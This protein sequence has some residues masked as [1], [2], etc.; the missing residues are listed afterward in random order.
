MSRG[1]RKSKR[2]KHHHPKGPSRPPAASTRPSPPQH[3]RAGHRIR[4]LAAIAVTVA[5]L[6]VVGFVWIVRPPPLHPE[7]WDVPEV[8][9]RDVRGPVARAVASARGALFERPTSAEA[10]GE[11][12]MVFDAHEMFDQAATCYGRAHELS[13][14]DFRWVYFLG[15]VN[16]L[17]GADLNA[18]VS[19]FEAAIRL[20]PDYVAV[21]YRFGEALV[22]HGRMAEARDTFGHLVKLSPDLAT[23]YRGLGQVLLTM[24]EPEP[25]V[26]HLLRAA[27]LKPDEAKIFVALARGYT[28]LGDHARAAEA[29]RRSKGLTGKRKLPDPV[30][31]DVE[32]RAVDPDACVT[33]A[34]TN[35][36]AGRFREAIP[37]LKRFEES[38]PD[39]AVAQMLLGLC[40]R[41]TGKEELA[42]DHLSR[43]VVLKDD[44]VDAHVQLAEIFIKRGL[45]RRAIG[46]YRRAL[47]HQPGNEVLR[48]RL[49]DLEDTG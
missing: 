12:G 46:H 7:Q 6:G 30:R 20:R 48:A 41:R 36:A 18:V 22:R 40:Y 3:H 32:L 26:R 13:P 23:G 42:I 37:D 4:W 39:H 33:R 15:I 25:A 49:R 43:A 1:R 16:D 47:V 10:W 31:L 8:D 44:L 9:M 35:I 21:Y 27:Q 38:A 34:Q 45:R 24:G 14:N 19:A 17:R 28:M 5:V 11:C 29:L 2:Q